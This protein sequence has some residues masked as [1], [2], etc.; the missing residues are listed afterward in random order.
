M[1]YLSWTAASKSLC[2]SFPAEISQASISP[3][4]LFVKQRQKISPMGKKKKKEGEGM[5][6]VLRES[7]NP[8]EE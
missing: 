4:H 8:S 3:L 6:T 2:V 1:S 5:Q 7:Q